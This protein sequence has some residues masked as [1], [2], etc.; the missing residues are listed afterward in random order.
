MSETGY[1][2]DAAREQEVAYP[3]WPASRRHAEWGQA[4][5]VVGGLVLLLAPLTLI[6]NIL[7]VS[8]GPSRMGMGRTEITLATYGLLIGLGLILLLGLAALAFAVISLMTARATRQSPALGLAGLF[9][10]LVG[11]ALFLF[12]AIDTIFVLVGWSRNPMR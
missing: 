1:T 2:P 12:V 8:I 4:A 11:L 5:L 6:V 3:P 9:V 10:S 7:L